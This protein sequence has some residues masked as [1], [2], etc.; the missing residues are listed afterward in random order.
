M[1]KITNPNIKMAGWL[2]ISAF[3]VFMLRYSVS[4]GLFDESAPDLASK[5]INSFSNTSVMDL[6]LLAGVYFLLS[7][8]KEEKAKLD[9][10][11]LFASVF[12]ALLYVLGLCCQSLGGFLLF[13]SHLP[14]LFML[15]LTMAAYAIV[16]YHGLRL[17]WM[18]MEQ[19]SAVDE[20]RCGSK[21]F[22]FFKVAAVIFLCWLPWLLMNYPCSFCRDATTSLRQWIGLKPWTSA[23]PPLGTA[24]MGLCYSLGKFLVNENLGAFL[25]CLFHS[26]CG[27]LVFAACIRELYRSGAS[28]RFCLLCTAFYGLTPLWGLF[29]QWFEK[30]FLYTSAFML[31]VVLLLPVVRERTCSPWKAVILGLTVLFASLLRASALMELFPV[32]FIVAI[33]LKRPSRKWLLSASI[34]SLLLFTLVSNVLYPALGITK[35]PSS[36][37]MSVPFQQTAK[38][39]LTYPDEVTPEEYEAINAVLPYDNFVNYDPDVADPI[40]YTYR[41]DDSAL[42]A[43]YKAWFQMFLKHPANYLETYF[44]NHWLDLTPVEPDCHVNIMSTYTYDVEMIGAYRV[45]SVMPTRL[46]IIIRAAFVQLPLVSLL[47]SPGAYTWAMWIC[48][49]QL[50]RKKKYSAFFMA[51]PGLMNILFCMASPLNGAIRYELPTVALL[52]L[53]LG[54][55]II[56]SRDSTG[57]N[58]K[59]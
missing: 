2:L 55:T 56:Q 4:G 3:V 58:I 7:A 34:T 41:G 25:Y 10:W 57:K 14:Q 19:K 54:W 18:W 15:L 44:T 39:C 49:L 12:F 40:K 17:L 50:L 29:A 42:P 30:D 8:K 51:I 59:T 28:K 24:I 48:A 52:P 21:P 16:F 22:P 26:V 36:E 1:K 45:F 43:Y 35:Y 33:W 9:A 38:Y 6:L 53:V 23:T 37:L 13:F 31:A 32:L 11:T 47:A 27:A 20:E 46:F 5:L